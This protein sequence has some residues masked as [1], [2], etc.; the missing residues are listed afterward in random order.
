MGSTIGK[1]RPES[2]K[3]VCGAGARLVSVAVARDI[4]IEARHIPIKE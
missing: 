4:S 1:G 2:W 3:G